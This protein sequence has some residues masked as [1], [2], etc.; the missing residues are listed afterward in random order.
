MKIRDRIKG[1]RRVRAADLKPH[2]RNWRTHPAEQ[3]N[4]LRGILAEVGFVD[5]LIAREL[6]DGTFELIDGHLRAETAAD[7]KVPVLIVDVTAEEAEK[8]LTT[9]DP[10]AAMAGRNSQ[11]LTELLG[12]VS[13][14]DPGLRELIAGLRE[15]VERE[16]ASVPLDCIEDEVPAPPDDTRRPSS[17]ARA[18]AAAR[19]RSTRRRSNSTGTKTTPS[20]AANRTAITF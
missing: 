6:P 4:A 11:A 10:L 7:A 8:I 1:L 5:A 13:T 16:L 18:P 12:S 3:Q 9:L 20:A 15:A 2:P 17:P 14:D 19:R